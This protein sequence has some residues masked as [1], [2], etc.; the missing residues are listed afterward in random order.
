MKENRAGCL[1]AMGTGLGL[2]SSIPG[3]VPIAGIWLFVFTFPFMLLG[4]LLIVASDAST[5]YKS[6]V[7]LSL[8]L[9]PVACQCVCLL[10][11]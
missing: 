7:S 5:R 6:I 11:V 9:V 8:I 4:I 2:L 10:H 1:P 3:C